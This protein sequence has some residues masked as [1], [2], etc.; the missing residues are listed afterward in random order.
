MVMMIVEMELM[1]QDALPTLLEAPADT[2]SG[3]V[4]A[5]TSASPSHSSAMVKMIAR[6]T[7]TSWVVVSS[8]RSNPVGKH[9]LFRITRDCRIPPSSVE[10]RPEFYFHHQLYCNGHPNPAGG[11][12]SQLG[13]CA[14]Q[15]LNDQQA[16]WR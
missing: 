1:S 8:K 13:A 3:N 14:R 15:M 16:G 10:C 12:A 7:V 11:L 6:I 9:F 4:Q 2:M 5:E